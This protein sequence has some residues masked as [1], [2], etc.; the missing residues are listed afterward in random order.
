M[1]L[2]ERELLSG[3]LT[4]LEQ[5]PVAFK[6]A[7]ADTMIK[8]AFLKRPDAPYIVMQN[9]V[10][11]QEAIKTLQQRVSDL[12]RQQAQQQELAGQNSTKGGL[13]ASL[14]NRFGQQQ[15]QAPS[16]P[17]QQQPYPPYGQPQAPQQGG[18][19]LKNAA[20]TALGVAG[21]MMLFEGLSSLFSHGHEAIGGGMFSGAETMS[22]T[23]TMPTGDANGYDPYS[24]S[25]VDDG[26]GFSDTDG[27]FGMDDGGDFF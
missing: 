20:G 18:S 8:E 2:Q 26:A 16:Q 13:F 21:G 1:T 24:D 19:F 12:E 22:P 14:G 23:E 4:K 6:D 5:M 15:G 10:M 9:L 11:M 27:G 7:E 3:A 25:F 17:Q